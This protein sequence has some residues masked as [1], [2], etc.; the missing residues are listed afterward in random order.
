M[1]GYKR[2]L[3]LIIIIGLYK[4][5]VENNII[6]YNVLNITMKRLIVLIEANIIIIIISAVEAIRAD[7][8][9]SNFKYNLNA[10]AANV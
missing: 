4:I 9:L 1:Q 8:F 10:A 3:I 6:S 2:I 7:F 5:T